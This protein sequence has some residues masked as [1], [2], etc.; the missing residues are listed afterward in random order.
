MSETRILV[1]GLPGTGKTTFIAALWCYVKSNT[2][3]KTLAV[4]SLAGVEHEYLN[5]IANDYMAYEIPGRSLQNTHYEKVVMPLKKISDS[6]PVTLEIPDIAGEKFRDHFDMREWSKEYDDL[7]Q[8]VKGMLVFVSPLSQNNRPQFIA[9]AAEMEALLEEEE[10]T[11]EKET[12]AAAQA[13]TMEA[14]P[15][16]TLTN[17]DVKYVP[18]Q[19]KI[20]EGLQF[21]LH[22]KNI[23]KPLKLSVIIS[24]WDTVPGTEELEPETW[25]EYNL[26]LLHQYLQCNTDKF[27]SRCF[28]V[29]GQGCD[30]NK[31]E[32]VDAIAGKPVYERITV[33]HGTATTT[34]I[35]QPIIWM[36]E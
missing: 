29:S 7:L 4:N 18:N 30:Y 12:A 5:S 15:K 8:D 28:G 20:V 34:D 33:K 26:P 17:W 23:A 2:T 3:A 24:A 31:E 21:L 13:E 27:T 10:E 36:T 14:P 35:T 16:P 25:L 9:D 6:Q 11:S 22:H 1:S 19:V 32:Q